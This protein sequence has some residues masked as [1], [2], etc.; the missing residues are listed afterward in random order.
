MIKR[1]GFRVIE[2]EQDN[3]KFTER[4]YFE[5]YPFWKDRRQLIKFVE[6]ELHTPQYP[7]MAYCAMYYKRYKAQTEIMPLGTLKNLFPKSF[8]D[9]LDVGEEYDKAF[10]QERWP[11]D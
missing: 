2:S 5:I 1:F 6:V 11:N 10:P 3:G 7:D 4:E 9:K 8:S